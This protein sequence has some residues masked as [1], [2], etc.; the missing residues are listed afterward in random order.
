MSEERCFS[1]SK[2]KTYIEC[3]KLYYWQ[4]IKKIVTIIKPKPLAAGSTIAEALETFRVTGDTEQALQTI[5]EV[6]RSEENHLEL[7]TTD[8][9]I[10]SVGNLTLIM[11]DY[12]DM[13]SNEPER[14]IKHSYIDEETQ[15][16]KTRV[17][18]EFK[19]PLNEE[20]TLFYQGRIDGLYLVQPNE[21]AIIEDKTTTRMG[22]K[23]FDQFQAN[24]QIMWYMWVA[25]K[26]GAFKN[27]MP[28]CLVNAIYIHKAE[29]RLKRNVIMKSTKQLELAYKDLLNWIEAIEHAEHTKN[30][31]RNL[32]HCEMWGGCS[33]KMLRDI[34]KPQLLDRII[35]AN[36]KKKEER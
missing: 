9:P 4:Y 10:R 22:E 18:V 12:F 8:D 29:R 23:Y 19:V 30:F 11:L 31:P 25:N 1:H 28:R 15:Q 5:A 26:L 32:S 7:S 13:Y 24:H 27:S 3:P 21:I 17:E 20:K 14:V 36:F 6:G 34:E 16:E 35:N 33:Y 2:I